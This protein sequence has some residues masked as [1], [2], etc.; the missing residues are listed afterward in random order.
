MSTARAPVSK[1]SLQAR[2]SPH[3]QTHTDTRTH[4]RTHSHAHAHRRARRHALRLPHRSSSPQHLLRRWV[5]GARHEDGGGGVARVDG[6]IGLHLH[7]RR[8]LRGRKLWGLTLLCARLRGDLGGGLLAEIVGSDLA[9][10][11]FQDKCLCQNLRPSKADV[12]DVRGRCTTQDTDRTFN[13]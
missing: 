13:I 8:G 7:L 4:A 11:F 12:R 3:T 2:A 10:L 6:H 1:K 5:F 9:F